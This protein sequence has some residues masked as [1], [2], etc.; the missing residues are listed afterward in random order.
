MRIE[1]VNESGELIIFEALDWM[2]ATRICE[3][4]GWTFVTVKEREDED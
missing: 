2:N 4:N 1:A 3:E